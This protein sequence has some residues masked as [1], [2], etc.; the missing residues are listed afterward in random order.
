M[1]EAKLDNVYVSWILLMFKGRAAEVWHCD[2]IGEATN[3][4]ACLIVL[5]AP[6]L[7][8]SGKEVEVWHCVIR[9]ESLK[10]GCEG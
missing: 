5:E 4:D 9:S 2:S 6:G 7:K 10:I 1:S 8:V 3:D